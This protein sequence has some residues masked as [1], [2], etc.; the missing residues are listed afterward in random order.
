MARINHVAAAL[1]LVACATTTP[2]SAANA[3]ETTAPSAPTK[4][5]L[6]A[7]EKSAYAAWKSKDAKF[8]DTFLSDNFVGYGVSGKLDKAAAT[9]EYTAANCAIKS[10][11]ISDEQ[12]KPIGDNAALL[13]FKGTVDGACDG[14][15]LQAN[16][17]EASVYIRDGHQWKNI[18][19]AESPIVDPKATLATPAATNQ[20]PTP[21][22]SPAAPNANTDALLAVEKAVWEAWKDHD[23][24][25]IAALTA[26]N[27]SFINIFGTYLATKS[28]ALKNWSGAGCNVKTV[29]VT[30]ATTTMLSP[31]AAI[32]TFNATADGTCYGQKVGPVHG[33]SI[34]VKEGTT[35]E[36][37]FGIN[38]PA[39]L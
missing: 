37:T 4:Q 16:S 25:K 19:H 18:F 13:T 36:W 1:V 32:L 27:I 22:L 9:K 39:H 21:A 23:A 6:V 5:A 34:Y 38:V 8:W 15:T 30:D 10:Y 24:K 11:A 20:T 12:M 14:Q 28:D 29:N 7:L 26:N 3:P 17:R 2:M 33:T 31:T 35:W